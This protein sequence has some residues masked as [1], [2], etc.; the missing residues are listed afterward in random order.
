M[1]N[2]KINNVVK[3]RVLS[4]EKQQKLSKNVTSSRQVLAKEN[5]DTEKKKTNDKNLIKLSSRTSLTKNDSIEKIRGSVIVQGTSSKT[6]KDSSKNTS[7]PRA[8]TITSNSK[9]K[10][11]NDN[12]KRGVSSI[13]MPK[14]TTKVIK[15]DKKINDSMRIN[16]STSSKKR[17]SS[18][19]RR[20]R[21]RTLSPSEVKMLHKNINE[22]LHVK[23]RKQ[24]SENDDDY[25][26]DFED[27]ES[28]FQDCTESEASEVSENSDE[29]SELVEL[30][31]IK[32]ESSKIHKYERKLIEN[33]IQNRKY[34]EEQMLDSGNY[35][36][37]EAKKRAAKL[38]ASTSNN[39]DKTNIEIKKLNTYNDDK[40]QEVSNRSLLSSADE[41]F[42][43]GRSGDFVKL[44]SSIQLEQKNNEN[45]K[46][47][48]VINN[49]LSKKYTRGQQ[50]SQMI[51]LD[52][53][54]WSI[55]ESTPVAYEEFIS[56]HGKMNTRQIATQT[57][58]DCLSIEIQTDVIKK[59]NMWCQYPITCTNKL[60]TELDIKKFKKETIGVGCDDD[61]DEDD[62][63]LND[64]KYTR[65]FYDVL[66]L[67]E[68]LENAGK[69]ILALLEE[70]NHKINKTINNIENLKLPFSDSCIKLNISIINFLIDRPIT[71]IRYSDKTNKIILTIHAPS[72][73]DVEVSKNEINFITDCCIGCQW[74]IHEPSRPMKIFYSSSNITAACFHPTNFNIIFAGLDDGSL[75]L[76]DLSED[77][78]YHRKIIDNNNSCE[79][80]IR[81]P[82][83][84]TTACLNQHDKISKIIGVVV[85]SKID[86]DQN[87]SLG[88]FMP[89]QICSLDENG[90]CRVWS[91][92]RNLKGNANHDLGQSWWGKIRLVPSQI[93]NLPYEKIID[94]N[95]LNC[96][97]INID[98][99]DTNSLYIATNTSKVIKANR[100]GRNFKPLE[101]NGN[102]SGAVGT[103]YIENCPFDQPYFLVG[104]TDGTIRLHNT[105]TERPILQLNNYKSSA[106]IKTIQWSRSRPLTIF[107]LDDESRIYLWDLAKSDIIPITTIL[108]NKLVHISS[109]QLSPC[110]NKYDMANQ[111]MALGLDNGTVE[112][113]KLKSQYCHQQQND[114]SSELEIL[115]KYLSVH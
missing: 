92:L 101:F 58:D 51:K 20:R 85:L 115:L 62:D 35:E 97:D 72:D 39:I 59:R 86:N 21:S 46:K 114:I 96:T 48:S 13:Y 37:Q 22:N 63:N 74:N 73:E 78:T 29:S 24:S 34:D 109:I 16:E 94:K 45:I 65:P 56:L 61:E 11:L 28:D 113:H 93:I 67:N 30:E 105:T 43:D 17:I 100:N 84:S 87:D 88:K 53:V 76:W 81:C 15:N 47:Q 5:L 112:I 18:S 99:I 27:Y 25:E 49:K 104:C 82:T 98:N 90:N 26:D 80:I 3:K 75:S 8:S 19:E 50:L 91:V 38:E 44:Q 52:T 40:I 68:F 79:W 7:T 77:E 108:P 64:N 32:L 36:L 103:T 4:Q 95:Y 14:K 9:S 41:G 102:F 57:N 89:I 10:K 31:P 111:Y 2:T 54:E 110:R 42:E 60:N 69:V 83:F 70:K 12:D 1:N 66:Q 33:K 106:S 55:Y 107:A 6:L 23:N 71:M